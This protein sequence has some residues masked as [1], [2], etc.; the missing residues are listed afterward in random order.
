MYAPAPRRSSM[1]KRNGVSITRSPSRPAAR[2]CAMRA[3]QSLR[4]QRILAADVDVALLAAGRE[5]GDRHRLD[6]GERVLFHQHAILERAGLRLV[7]IADH[8]VRARGCPRDRV[9]LAAGRKERAAAADEARVRHLADDA[10]GAERERACERLVAAMRAIVVEALRIRDADAAKQPR[11]DPRRSIRL[12][13][14]RGR[15]ASPRQRTSRR[16]VSCGAR[17][18]ASSRRGSHSGAAGR[19]RAGARSHW[20]R[21]GLRTHIA[22]PSGR[23]F[24]GLADLRSR[25]R[26]S[27][28]APVHAAG[29]VVADVH[30]RRRPRLHREHARRTTRRRTPPRAAPT[31]ARRCDSARLR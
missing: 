25:S 20:P 2:A 28:S 11:A 5:R 19:A 23:R 21:H 13:P 27:A 22:R 26:H 12:V 24:A 1:S 16:S 30:H 7:G 6:H 14:V 4:R 31:A 3:E 9:P 10:G 18:S 29:D 17:R 8:V 15:T